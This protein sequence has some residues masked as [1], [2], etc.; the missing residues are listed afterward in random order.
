MTALIGYCITYVRTSLKYFFPHSRNL[1][2]VD[3]TPYGLPV[4][5][6]KHK[7]ILEEELRQRRLLIVGDVHGCH[8]E[9]VE[10]LDKCEG[11]RPNVALVF[12][13]DL[14]NK[15][16]KNAEV[17]TMVREM[18]GYC[19]RG[20]HD[21]VCLA[22]WQKYQEGVGP[23]NPQ[24]EWLEDLSTED[25]NWYFDLPFS[26]YFPSREVIIVHAGLVPEVDLKQQRQDDLIHMR[27]VTF[28]LR[29][30]TFSSADDATINI[31]PWGQAWAGPQHV[32]FGH[33]ALR[34][35]QRYPFATGLDTACVYGGHLTALFDDRRDTLIQIKAH[36]VHNAGTKTDDTI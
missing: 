5:L 12:V 27:N 18:G 13:G 4:P 6:I 33:D 35:L 26:I 2:L 31:Q 17:V 3:R 20:N 28:D 9:L 24:F 30:L 32:Y 1:F 29:T 16:P 19:V 23:L 14:C 36:K 15:G 34:F 8:D 25:L 22:E 21:E 7:V 10:L 11:R